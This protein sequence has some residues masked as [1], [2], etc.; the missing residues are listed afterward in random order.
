MEK[1]IIRPEDI[2]MNIGTMPLAL[3]S[4]NGGHGPN[5]CA[6]GY[7]GSIDK[8]H[9]AVALR[10]SRYTYKLAKENG[11]F[12]VNFL[13]FTHN[14]IPDLAKA[15]DSSSPEFQARVTK[16]ILDTADDDCIVRVIPQ[17]ILDVKQEKSLELKAALYI[18]TACDY[19]GSV[20]GR[21]YDKFKE[22]G[23]TAKNAVEIDV[24][25][26]SQ[27]AIR[28][29]CKLVDYIES[30]GRPGS[31][32]DLLIGE[33]KEE[34]LPVGPQVYF[35][36]ASNYNYRLASYKNNINSI[37]EDF[38]K[39]LFIVTTFDGSAHYNPNIGIVCEQGEQTIF[40]A[41]NKND[42]SADKITEGE[43]VINILRF[44]C[45]S[46]FRKQIKKV[47]FTS[48]KSETV[49]APSIQEAHTNL[50]CIL[51]DEQC[52]QGARVFTARI[53]RCFANE[54][55][56]YSP[57]LAMVV[58]NNIIKNKY[59]IGKMFAI[60]EIERKER[61]RLEAGRLNGYRTK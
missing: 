51:K 59:V 40:L 16:G 56:D 50:E 18:A 26:I 31:R 11:G 55:I 6:A 46:K 5:V 58:G 38:P 32:H 48:Q 8:N 25:L 60:Y 36:T 20:S 17:S 61:M 13:S 30:P 53:T 24:P 19:C 21:R 44:S 9:I 28:V 41:Y 29:A 10:P 23:L 54:K 12:G 52:I 35:I 39:S 27:C 49:D 34:H 42:E 2:T 45:L 47:K 22:T 4:T 3:I 33:V 57:D 1:R 37:A 43:F 7:I 14:Q 15:Y